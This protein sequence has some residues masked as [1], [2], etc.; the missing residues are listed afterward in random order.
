MKKITLFFFLGFA[1]CQNPSRAQ[2]VNETVNFDNYVSTTD[3]DFVNRF[4]IGT[5]LNQI[6]TNG[7]TGG[8][9]ETPQTISWGNDNAVYCTRFKGVIGETYTTAISFKYD[10]SQFNNINFDRPVSLTMKPYTDPNHYI[11]ASVLDSRKIQIVSYSAGSSSPTM[12]LVSGHWYD[13]VLTADFTGGGTHDEIGM[14]AQVNDLGVTGNDPPIPVSFTN[15]TLFDTITIA[16]TSIEV[17][18][19]GTSWG[20]AQYLDNFRFE[21]MKS[22]DNCIST[23]LAENDFSHVQIAVYAT[24]MEVKTDAR[25]D[26]QI[27]NL[28]GEKVAAQ[29]ASSGSTLFDI[30]HLPPGLY[31]VTISNDKKRVTEKVLLRK[32]Y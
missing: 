8:C 31:F 22:Y 1:L 32:S 23:A 17:S 29:T 10:T 19:T 15:A 30:H 27:Y 25:D 26:I 12:N 18:V 6:Q 16:D 3:N 24:T 14:N 2:I 11:I 7:I 20:G 5:G 28:L 21:G 4:D 9:L 13:L